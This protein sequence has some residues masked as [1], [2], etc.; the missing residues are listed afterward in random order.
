MLAIIPAR[1]GSKGLPRKNIKLLNGKPLI[2]YTIEAALAAK[3]I[4]RVIVN[5]DNG[6]IGEIALKFGAEV[7]FMRSKELAS[8]TAKSIDV[9]KD[10]IER[11]EKSSDKTIEEFVV[12]Q[13]TSPLRAAQHID[14]A[15]ELFQKKKADSVISYCQEEHPIFWHKYLDEEGKFEDIFG[16]TLLQNRQEIRPSYYANGA[17]YIFNK[18][19]IYKNTYYTENS[20]AYIMDKKSSIDIDTIDDFEYCEYLITRK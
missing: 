19:L 4:N 16:K 9:L 18:N 5:T 13:P 1:G 15:I 8:D 10:A 20:Y 2:A 14:G 3:Y 7:P 12:L 11:L 6:E 17:I